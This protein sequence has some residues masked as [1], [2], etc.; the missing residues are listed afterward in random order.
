[1]QLNEAD[2]RRK[3]QNPREIIICRYCRQDYLHIKD[4]NKD[5]ALFERRVQCARCGSSFSVYP[6]LEALAEKIAAK[7]RQNE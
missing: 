6:A 1:M 3:L 7:K 5:G 4:I 2:A